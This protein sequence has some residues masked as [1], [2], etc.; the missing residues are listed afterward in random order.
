MASKKPAKIA[1]KE[2]R[3]SRPFPLKLCYK[4]GKTIAAAKDYLTVL[5]INR[6]DTSRSSRY[7]DCHRTCIKV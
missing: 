5:V 1:V 3:S 6:N 4:C 2:A 7:Q